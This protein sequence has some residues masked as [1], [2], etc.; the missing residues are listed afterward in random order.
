[1]FH[2][3]ILILEILKK[4]KVLHF[5]NLIRS[6][7]ISGKPG[8]L[9]FAR[10]ILALGFFFL[11]GISGYS[12][13]DTIPPQISPNI[14][15]GTYDK[16]L[17]IQFN[18]S[19]Q[20]TIFYTLNGSNPTRESSKFSGLITLSKPGKTTLKFF[21]VDLVGNQ[22]KIFSQTYNI[23]TADLKV[24]VDMDGG[25]F[26]RD[27]V[28]RALTNLPAIVHFTLNGTPPTKKIPHF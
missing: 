28:V 5:V 16:I 8:N 12:Q 27:I 21:G 14:K 11:F 22:S 2:K 20:S 15:G 7:F 4:N 25:N 6:L 1:M 18:T 24:W 9:F 13:V 3:Y 10:S 17:E 19:E 23:E 26:N